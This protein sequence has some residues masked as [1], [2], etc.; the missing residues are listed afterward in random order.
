MSWG[1]FVALIIAIPL[2]T[3]PAAFVWYVNGGALYH[4]L[5]NLV[6]ARNPRRHPDAQQQA[7]RA[8]GSQQGHG[9]T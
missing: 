2:I 6:S 3:F 5:R 4:A 8:A 7:R 9:A 1:F